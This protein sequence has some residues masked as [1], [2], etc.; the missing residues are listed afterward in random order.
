MAQLWQE[1]AAQ[2]SRLQQQPW[3]ISS[4]IPVGG[5][6]INQ[7]YKITDQTT[8]QTYF[9][10][11]N[12]ASHGGMFE[13]E[14]IALREIANT[15]AITVPRP[16][17][18]GVVQDQA[19]LVLEYLELNH[20]PQWSALAAGLA[21]LHQV[22]SD[23]GFGWGQ[24]NWIGSTPQVN[25]WSH[26]WLEFFGKNRLGYQLQLAQKRGFPAKWGDRLLAKLPQLLADHQ[27]QP[28]LVHGDLWRGN[29]GFTNN[30]P[31]IFDPAIYFGDREVD[32]AMT[33]LFGG[34]DPEFYRAY[35]QLF[36]LPSGYQQRRQ[37]YNLYHI[38]NHFHLFG[39]S[40]EDQA[41][42]LIERLLVA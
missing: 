26:N 32:L 6:S 17:V 34:F 25:G 13:T 3:Q 40:Y 1:I 29:V 38:L 27:P 7:T 23:R 42:S 36:P 41:I 24:T 16:L 14:A 37:L 12:Q 21:R 2:I 10:K 9:I 20:P 15:Q 19:Y 30:Q 5:G 11:L 39:G 28:V 18:W 35:H 4:K 22:S 33:E 31:V 8:N